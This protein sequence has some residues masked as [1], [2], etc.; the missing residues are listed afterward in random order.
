MQV[1][2][3]QALGKNAIW[4]AKP[5]KR[6]ATVYT[7]SQFKD[8]TNVAEWPAMLD[9]VMDQH[10]RFRQAVDAVGGLAAFA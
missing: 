1:Q 3:E 10:V 9:W 8:I 4:D 5:G 6:A 2:F 7:Q